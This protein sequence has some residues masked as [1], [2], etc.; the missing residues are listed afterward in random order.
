[1]TRV[2]VSDL[3]DRIKIYRNFFAYGLDQT[4]KV[5]M[6]DEWEK[7]LQP[8]DAKDINKNLD[9]FVR[10]EENKD[11]IPDVFQ[12][13]RNTLTIVDKKS[14]GKVFTRCM[15]CGRKIDYK[16]EARKHEDRCRSIRYMVKLN[17]Q[18]YNKELDLP[19]LY[20]M[21]DKEFNEIYIKRLRIILVKVKETNPLEARGIENVIET[22]FGRPPKYKISEI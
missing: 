4:Q 7:V 21:Q 10:S 17:K 14:K 2:E 9:I 1:M 22:Y 13:V 6:V 20:N 19:K 16:F 3:L 18:F 12:L 8:Y 5:K 15:F 11:K